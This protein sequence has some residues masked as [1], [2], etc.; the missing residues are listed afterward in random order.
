MIKN[1]KREKSMLFFADYFPV[2][3]VRVSFMPVKETPRAG[4]G[5]G[6]WT[7]VL[8]WGEWRVPPGP[9]SNNIPS[10]NLCQ[11]SDQHFMR[12]SE[13][14]ETVKKPVLRTESGGQ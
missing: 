11:S 2:K 4:P 6:T 7:R 13:D 14:L 9:G 5:L 3:A 10:S 1:M 8:G 12:H